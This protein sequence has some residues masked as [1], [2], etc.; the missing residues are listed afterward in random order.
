MSLMLE[1]CG[2]M[3]TKRWK[4]LHSEKGEEQM[5]GGAI[6]I[7]KYQSLL[8]AGKEYMERHN[9]VARREIY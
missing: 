9:Q 7:L 1:K 5:S 2:R 4:V 6:C 8:A 3:M